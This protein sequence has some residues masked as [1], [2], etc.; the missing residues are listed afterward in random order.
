MKPT[1]LI[2]A[3]LLLTACGA[4]QNASHTSQTHTPMLG[5]ANPASVFCIEQGGT[6]ENRK[7]ADGAAYALCHLP[8]GSVIEEWELFRSKNAPR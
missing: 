4:A 8:D 5:M 2:G 6:S 7:N 1:L 3:S